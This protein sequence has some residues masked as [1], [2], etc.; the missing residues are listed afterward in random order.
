MWIHLRLKK[1]P[2]KISTKLSRKNGKKFIKFIFD[3]CLIWLHIGIPFHIWNV[4]TFLCPFWHG[5]YGS[6]NAQPI[7]TSRH[8]ELNHQFNSPYFLLALSLNNRK[9]IEYFPPLFYIFNKYTTQYHHIWCV[10]V[11]GV[12]LFVSVNNS[13]KSL[14]Q[15]WLNHGQHTIHHTLSKRTAKRVSWKKSIGRKNKR[16]ATKCIHVISIAESIK[17]S[18][19]NNVWAMQLQSQSSF[20]STTDRSKHT[21][22]RM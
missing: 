18:S 7:I 5:N 3:V 8:A 15:L 17:C 9:K 12:T 20:R 6:S 22:K 11:D 1:W 4:Y 19:S 10:M 2:S 21:K 16:G 14:K 13:K